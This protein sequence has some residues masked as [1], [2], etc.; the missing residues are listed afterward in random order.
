MTRG[1][2][3]ALVSFVFLF[4]LL[5][6]R[7]AMAHTSSEFWNDTWPAGDVEYNMTFGVPGGLGSNQHDQIAA[8]GGKWNTLTNFITFK[9]SGNEVAGF[10]GS[11]CTG[12]PNAIHWVNLSNA[13]AFTIQCQNVIRTAMNRFQITF[14]SSQNWYYGTSGIPSGY[15]MI[16]G[17]AAHEFGHASGGWGPT[18]SNHFT[19]TNTNGLCESS[20]SDADFH[21]MCQ[22]AG[23]RLIGTNQEGSL[24]SHD[25]HTFQFWY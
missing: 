19:T 8:G 4:A 15:Y 16:S 9:R 18:N 21:T 13:L 6:A 20:V 17:V 2:R 14:D 7:P 22:G 24:E 1:D 11:E 5:G 10:D 23:G 12:E 25:I 3:V